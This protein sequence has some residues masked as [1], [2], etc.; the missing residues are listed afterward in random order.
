MGRGIPS[1]RLPIDYQCT[2]KIIGV[3]DAYVCE[4]T[5]EFRNKTLAER[6]LPMPRFSAQDQLERWHRML[7]GTYRE[8]QAVVRVKTELENP[9]P[10]SPRLASTKYHRHPKVS[11]STCGQQIP[12]WPLYNLA[13]GID[14]HLDGHDPYHSGQRTLH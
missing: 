7:N 11:S 1:D 8:G 4:S 10:A 13:A 9:N 14:D 6:S 3:G 12:I 5:P 2:E